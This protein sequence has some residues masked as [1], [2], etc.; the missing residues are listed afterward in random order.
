MSHLM[1]Q[2]EA[3][4]EW[5][6]SRVTIQRAIKAGKLSLTTDKR[7]DPAEM[8]RAFGEPLGRSS[9]NRSIPEN[10]G[11]STA[12]TKVLRAEI[13]HLKAMLAE[14]DTHIDDLRQALRLGHDKSAHSRRWWP[15]AKA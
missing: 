12:Q 15:W 10:T 1:S 4:Q 3:A 9:A 7:I 5:G 13:E 6:M 11:E 2:R 14:K 8:L